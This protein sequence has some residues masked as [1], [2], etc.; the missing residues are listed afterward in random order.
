[1]KEILDRLFTELEDEFIA[2]IKQ[3]DNLSRSEQIRLAYEFDALREL[4][5]S[6]FESIVDAI[7]DDYFNTMQR[8]EKFKVDGINAVTFEEMNILLEQDVKPVL[9]SGE[10]YAESFKA[11]LLKSFIRG[12]NVNE[13]LRD[14]NIPGFRYNW[15]ITAIEQAKSEFEATATAKVFED[16]PNQKF[17]LV[18]ANDVRTRPECKAVLKY[19][20]KDGFTKGEVDSGSVTKIVKQHY[21]EFTRNVLKDETLIYSWSHRGGFN[22]RHRWEPV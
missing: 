22:C 13:I 3:F 8:L 1:M 14:Y 12:E 16:T 7:Q 4:Y 2:K 20:P 5:D 21:M 11:R 19:Q 15:N 17:K 18:G 9:R 6:G 10:A